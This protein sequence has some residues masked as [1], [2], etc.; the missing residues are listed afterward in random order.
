MNNGIQLPQTVMQM[1]SPMN[2]T[3][4]VSMMAVHCP[5]ESAGAKV[6]FALEVMQEAMRQVNS[7]EFLEE[8]KAIMEETKRKHR[9]YQRKQEE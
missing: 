3:Q 7:P 2:D 6:M 5:G 9:V 1:V 4:I 8:C